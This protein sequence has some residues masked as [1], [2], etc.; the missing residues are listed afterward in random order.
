[1]TEVKALP[2]LIQ[3]RG[4]TISVQGVAGGTEVS[5]YGIDGKKEGT[6]IGDGNRAVIN[7][8]LTSGNTAIV[9][10]GDKAVKVMIK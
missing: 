1:M 5:V 2:V 4:G 9:K 8:N 7:T 6:A 3:T 10:I